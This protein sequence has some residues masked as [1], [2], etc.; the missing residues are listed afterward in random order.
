MLK[1]TATYLL[2][3]LIAAPLYAEEAKPEYDHAKYDSH[4]ES[5]A[6][7]DHIV[8]TVK[9]SAHQLDAY[10]KLAERYLH[11]STYE[12]ARKYYMD[13]L[14]LDPGNVKAQRKLDEIERLMMPQLFAQADLFD[15]KGGGVNFV[16]T[17]GG[18]I[19]LED[20]YSMEAEHVINRR[21]EKGEQRYTRQATKIDISKSFADDMV[22][23]FGGIFK[24]YGMNEDVAA[25]YYINAMKTFGHSTT[26][27]VTFTKEHQDHTR[28]ILDQRVDKYSLE[29]GI[30]TGLSDR[31]S[32]NADVTGAYFTEGYA[33]GNNASLAFSSS[34]IFHVI[35]E[36][37]VMDLSYTYYRMDFLRKS[38][39]VDSSEFEYEYYSPKV[40][41]SHSATIYISH[42]FFE[43]RVK[44]I[45]SD[46]VS[47][48]PHDD[49]ARNRIYAEARYKFTGKDSL[50]VVFSRNRCLASVGDSYQI[51]Q[52]ITLKFSHS[53]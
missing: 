25:D 23:F 24:Y 6:R 53:F 7:H 5:A 19:Y 10:N 12:K 21:T 26:F 28:D 37:P 4:R 31:F 32:L 34:P 11:A 41:Q 46:T 9:H 38:I 42:E 3:C 39:T 18:S 43:G 1:K 16:Q 8:N 47:Y 13:I 27:D 20:G 33:P 52:Q 49:S 2:V 50:S 44:G 30:H 14:S 35:K 17:Y 15:V 29:A 36:G 48:R 40:F 51:T 22:L 45:F